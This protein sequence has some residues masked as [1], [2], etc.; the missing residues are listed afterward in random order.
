M[1]SLLAQFQKVLW[2]W[3]GGDLDKDSTGVTRRAWKLL[4]VICPILERAQHYYRFLFDTMRNLD[5]CRKIFSRVRS[6]E[7]D[8]PWDLL[9]AL[10]N[11]LHFI[12][13]AAN[14]SWD[15][16]QLWAWGHWQK[17]D[18]HSPEDF[19][20]VVDYLDYIHSD[21]HE[22]AYDILLL[23]G[24][25]GVSCS[26]AKQHL[27]VERLITYMGST[28]P[29]SLRHAAL[30]AAHSAREEIASIDATDDAKLRD[31]ILTELSPTILSVLCPRPSP[32][33]VD[34][35]PDYDDD[36]RNLCYL[37]LVCT[38]ARNSSWHPHL[39][40]DHHIDRCI[41]MIPEYCNP[42]S[43]TQHAFY[44]AGT[45]LRIVPKSVTS[46][47]SVTEQQWWD[48]MRS[49]WNDYF[50]IYNTQCFEL[51][52]LIVEG[53]KKYM[54]IASKSDLEQLIR[55]VD[56]ILEEIRREMQLKMRLQE[57]RSGNGTGDGTGDARFRG[58]RGDRHCCEGV[59]DYS[60]QH[61][62]EV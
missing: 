21:G 61:A 60:Q 52:P 44:L 62:G 31:V 36:R 7:Q 10:R 42:K 14:V 11:A 27:F 39:Y 20:W 13:T 43:P 56:R 5:V 6:S 46:L 38:L 40:G 19:D 30:R 9:D 47:D 34:D 49:A 45:L 33:P 28:M 1:E 26:P 24:S 50:D 22:A 35:S 37:E 53:T 16:A 18:S 59:D 8:Y 2:A 54:R 29:D 51:L 3:D 4:T 17:G 32:T 12:F 23:L 15:P 55:N 25:M 41:S 48:V 57:M 58:G